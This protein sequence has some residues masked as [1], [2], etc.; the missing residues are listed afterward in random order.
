MPSMQIEKTDSHR[1]AYHEIFLLA[2]ARFLDNE[3]KI[4]GD[5]FCSTKNPLKSY[6][7]RL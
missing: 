4:A 1:K 2:E 7:F 5:E 6:R 3:L